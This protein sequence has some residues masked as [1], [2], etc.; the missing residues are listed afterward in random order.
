[1]KDRYIHAVTC[2]SYGPRRPLLSQVVDLFTREPDTDTGLGVYYIVDLMGSNGDQV[3]TIVCENH[4]IPIVDMRNTRTGTVRD[5]VKNIMEATPPRCAII[6]DTRDNELMRKVRTR[7]SNTRRD[8]HY[9]RVVFCLV[10]S[11]TFEAG[12]NGAHNGICIQFPGSV[13]DRMGMLM[14]HIPDR[15]H[16]MGLTSDCVRP[17]AQ[18][19]VDYVLFEPRVWKN[20]KTDGTLKELLSTAFYQVVS[21]ITLDTTGID[22]EYPSFEQ[23]WRRLMA[24]Q[25]ISTLSTPPKTMCPSIHR[26]IPVGVSAVD[27]MRAMKFAIPPSIQDPYAITVQSSAVDDKCGSIAITQPMC[28][29]VVNVNCVINPALLVEVCREIRTSHKAVVYQVHSMNQK[30]CQIENT[31]EKT[32]SLLKDQLRHIQSE[33]ATL[34]KLSTRHTE[35]ASSVHHHEDDDISAMCTRVG[36]SRAVK[37]RFRSGKLHKQCTDCHNRDRTYKLK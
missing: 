31:H 6:L 25:L 1:M 37:K 24:T 22:E 2:S 17:L 16:Q 10:D 12:V 29:T 34:V 28:Y 35:V 33:M 26:V 4:D 30:L 5:I 27:A 9:R 14:Y 36:C 15:F 23:G 8:L 13:E 18:V 19:M 7:I 3:V 11:R 20:V 32:C 21:R